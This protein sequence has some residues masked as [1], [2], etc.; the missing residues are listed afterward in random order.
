M[1]GQQDPHTIT[2]Y[3]IQTHTSKVYQQYANN[4]KTF[5]FKRHYRVFCERNVR[6]A[7]KKPCI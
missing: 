3:K 6:L 5:L 1:I 4:P 7:Y 2:A